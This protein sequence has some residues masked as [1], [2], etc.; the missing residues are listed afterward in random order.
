MKK[1]LSAFLALIFVFTLCG[2]FA[3]ADDEPAFDPE[4]A[5]GEKDPAAE[6]DI[7]LNAQLR[8][9]PGDEIKVIATVRNISHT[10]GVSVLTYDFRYDP[11][12]LEVANELKSD[13]TLD[14]EIKTPDPKAWENLTKPGSDDNDAP[15]PGMIR[16]ALANASTATAAAVKDGELTVTM[17]FKVKEETDGDVFFWVPNAPIL[18]S[19]AAFV[20]FTGNGSYVKV[21]KQPTKADVQQD[22]EEQTAENPGA[23][24]DLELTGP[25][26]YNS[27]RKFDITVTLKNVTAEGGLSGVDFLLKYDSSTLD[28]V[29]PVNNEG[30]VEASAAVPNES[31]WENLTKLERD[32][33]EEIVEGAIHVAYFNAVSAEDVAKNDGDF[34]VT[35]SFIGKADAEFATGIWTDSASI[36]GRTSDMKLVKGNGSYIVLEKEEFAFVPGDVNG[37]NRIDSTD[38]A[39][40]KRS[41]LGTFVLNAEQLIRGDIN[42][43]NRIDTREYAMIKRHFLGTY[44]IP[45]AEGK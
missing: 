7:R 5:L 18:A 30:I 1:L 24:F 15:V 6:F 38:Y 8:Y 43:N 29:T 2:A 3:V 16:V 40:A 33:N 20:N 26:G 28:L 34:S 39:M 14:V 45:G 10:A 19:D 22:M 13:G 37:N 36:E 44:V 11:E 42:G 31:T 4:A 32:E 35:L 41:Y 23:K 17:R 21:I 12:K 27:I 9:K 25:S